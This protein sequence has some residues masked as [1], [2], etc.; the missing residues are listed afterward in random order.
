MKIV[1]FSIYYNVPLLAIAFLIFKWGT[2]VAYYKN[3]FHREIAVQLLLYML[4]IISHQMDLWMKVHF[5]KL[6]FLFLR[7]L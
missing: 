3:I 4:V 1:S 5:R 7:A 2:I 6:V